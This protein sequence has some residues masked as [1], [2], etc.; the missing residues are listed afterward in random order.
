M[1]LAKCSVDCRQRRSFLVIFLF[2]GGA[3][4]GTSYELWKECHSH[5]SCIR[6]LGKTS[7]YPLLELVTLIVDCVDDAF[8]EHPF[9]N[10]FVLLACEGKW[11]RF[12]C[13]F[14]NSDH[15]LVSFI[16][17]TFFPHFIFRHFTRFIFYFCEFVGSE[18]NCL[19]SAR[20]MLKANRHTPFFSSFH[21]LWEVLI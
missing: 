15:Q 21:P 19:I 12:F 13:R 10:S 11:R 14:P 8:G 20:R 4:F 17:V 1:K 7:C 9:A 3:F 2:F 18:S 16:R 5:A 6:R